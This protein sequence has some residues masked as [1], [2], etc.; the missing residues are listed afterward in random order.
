MDSEL[1]CPELCS[2]YNDLA[3]T[4]G[5]SSTVHAVLLDFKK[6]FDKVPHT[7][8]FKKIQQ[9][10]GIDNKLISWIQDFLTGRSQQVVVGNT[11][12]SELPVCSGVP[13]GSVLGPTLFLIY[14]ND[15][16][17]AVN[18]NVSLYADDTLMYSEIRT[19]EDKVNF[20]TNINSLQDWSTTWKMP[21]NT[22]KCEVI[23][24]SKFDVDHHCT[25]NGSPL[26]RVGKTKSLGVI[27]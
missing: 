7:L 16:P 27:I 24:F 8:L 17:L 25:L 18:C 22:S 12:S 19:I 11:K 4:V 2:T 14:I 21:F 15:L 13:Q 3:K 20:Q 10:S 26:Q 6:A 9:I 23:V 5:E 1:V